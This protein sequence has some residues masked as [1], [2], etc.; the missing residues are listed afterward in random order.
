MCTDNNFE[1]LISSVQL[2]NGQLFDP[3]FCQA[4]PLDPG[5]LPVLNNETH[6]ISLVA[7]SLQAPGLQAPGFQAP[8]LQAPVFQAEGVE[9]PVLQAPVLQ[10]PGMQAPSFQAPVL[11]APVLQ[12]PSFQAGSL[13][14]PSLQAPSLQADSLQDALKAPDGEGQV[15][16]YYQ[17]LTYLVATNANVTTTYSADIAVQGLETDETWVELIAWQPNVHATTVIDLETGACLA[18]PEADN[19]VIAAVELGSPGFQAPSLQAPSLDDVS[20]P[21]AFSPGNQDPYAGAISFAG[22]PG[23]QIALTV[24]LWVTGTAKE[25]LVRL[26]ECSAADDPPEDCLPQEIKNGAFLLVPFGAAAHGCSTDDDNTDPSVDCINAGVEK[27]TPP[28][29]FAPVFF[30]E[31]GGSVAHEADSPNGASVDTPGTV[32]AGISVTDAD[33]TVQVS[34]D[35]QGLTLNDGTTQ[36]PFGDTLVS[37]IAVDTAENQSTAD[38][39]ISIIDTVDPQIT[40]PGPIT[41]EATDFGGAAVGFLVTATD[42][43]DTTIECTIPDGNSGTPVNSGATFPLGTTTVTCTA[44]DQGGNL[45]TNSFDVTVRDTTPPDLVVS[46]NLAFEAD[47]IGGRFVTY[48]PATATDLADPA[49]VVGCLPASNTVFDFGPTSVI[50]VATDASSNFTSGSFTVTVTDTVAPVFKEPLPPDQL[51]EATGPAGAVA[52]FTPPTATDLGEPLDVTCNANAGDPFPLG[53]TTVTCNTDP[54][55]GGNIASASF[56]ITVQDTTAPNVVVPADFTVILDDASGATVS[57]VVTAKDIVDPNPVVTC[58]SASGSLFPPGTTTVSCTATDG[59]GNISV[60]ST[61]D[62]TVE[63]GEGAGLS[64]KKSVKSGAVAPFTWVWTD[65]SGNPV[66][67]GLGNQDIEARAGQCPSDLNNFDVLNEDPGSSGFQ[68]KDGNINQY[69]WQ[70]VD[71]ITGAD[72]PTDNY[73]VRVTLLTNGQFQETGIIV[74]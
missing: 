71:D 3:L 48:A 67:V 39:T 65:S 37:C 70:T 66:D 27:I 32:P 10:A 57:Y 74:R 59:S 38:I 5:C 63:L 17:D 29:L 11:Q 69:N 64:S 51:I 50:C 19:Y 26:H 25:T 55:G 68:L 30:P 41:E 14:S 16:I 6:N 35:S 28:D 54:D 20:L 45:A 13:I 21:V 61:F 22:K 62:V 15:D 23:D 44:T 33:P 40:V 34:C 56:D 43:T 72:L 46:G 9:A 7:P 31:D 53:T 4:N 12:A 1:S 52:T 42:V 73:C 2:G 49:P 47:Q 58:S 36:F 24:R 18:V 8:V 60:P